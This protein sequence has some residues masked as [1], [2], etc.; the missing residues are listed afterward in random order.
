MAAAVAAG[1]SF[2]AQAISLTP[3]SSPVLFG[4]DTS[5]A[6]ITAK[7]NAAYPGLD[8][9]YK[10]ER[11]P[12]NEEGAFAGSYVTAFANTSPAG[13]AAVI[14]YVGPTAINLN[15]A[16]A[17]IKD[18]NTSPAWYLFDISGWNGTDDIEFSGFFKIRQGSK[19]ISHVSIYGVQVTLASIP[20]TVPDGAATLALLGLGLVGMAGF[21]RIFA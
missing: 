10:A 13:S 14:S 7:I 4:D 16:Y 5:Q 11:S 21:R 12:S 9:L 15:P 20:T 6:A 19:D 18:G 3:S 2:Y 8:L 17:L 1:F